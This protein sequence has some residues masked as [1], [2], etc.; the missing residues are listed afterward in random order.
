[1]KLGAITAL[2]LISSATGVSRADTDTA[3]VQQTATIQALQ[4]Q[5]MKLTARLDAL[6]NEKSQ[7]ITSSKP[8]VSARGAAQA[9]ALEGIKFK[10]DFRFRQEAFDIEGRPDRHRSRLR[11]RVALVAPVNDNVAVGFGLASG[12]SDP[13]SANQTLGTVSSSKQINLDLAYVNWNLVNSDIVVQAG[14]FK[15][16]LK[17]VG[18]TTLIW[19]GDVRPEG[20]SASVNKGSI[21]ATGLASWVDE[22]SRDSDLILLAGQAGSS[23]KLEN[24]VSILFGLSYY[25][26]TA[27]QGADSLF[28]IPANDNRLDING[29]YLNGFQS[30]EGFAEIG[31]P[32]DVGKVTLFADY[33]QNLDADDFNTGYAVG[34]KLNTTKWSFAW[35]YRD[36]EADAVFAALADSDFIGG[37]TDG[38]GHIFK[39]GYALS[40]KISLSSSFFLTD[41]NVDF[42]TEESFR[43][44]MLDI[45][46]KH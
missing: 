6:E 25:N 33:V 18:G 4:A 26:I 19:D 42:G 11:S 35:E 40:K 43:R 2:L 39:T 22:N 21:F 38:E 32:A 10:G 15:N 27:S 37:G 20:I 14:K 5:L 9:K 17:R 23:F 29:G 3:Y 7:T 44:L 12:G 46:F 8:V 24:N 28:G 31:I 13:T 36:V 45:S 1:M 30:I 41:R 34:A 16:P